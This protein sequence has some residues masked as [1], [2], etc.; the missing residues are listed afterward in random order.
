MKRLLKFVLLVLTCLATVVAVRTAGLTSKQIDAEPADLLAVDSTAVATKLS[1]AIQFPTVSYL[2][3]ERIDAAA[4]SAFDDW[5]REAFPRVHAGLERET[6]GSASLLFTWRGSEPT[7]PPSLLTAHFDVVPVEPGTENKWSHPPFS[8]AIAEG[9]VWGR[10]AMDDKMGVITALEAVESLLAQGFRPRRTVWLFFGADE[11]VSGHGGAA[12]FSQR[13]RET[14]TVPYFLLD[15]WMPILEG[16]IPGVDRPV[17]LVRIAEKAYLTVEVSAESEG[18]H[19]S[20]PPL[21]GAVGILARALTRIEDHPMPARIDGAVRQMFDVLAPEMPLGQRAVFANLWLFEPL[22]KRQLAGKPSTNAMIRTSAALT[23]LKGSPKDNVL[24]QRASAL[25]NFR[26]LPGDTVE[27]VLDHLRRTVRDPRVKLA[28]L[29]RPA[30]PPPPSATETPA[31]RAIE[32]AIR[33]VEP[34]ALVAP[35][36]LIG[37]SDARYY[38]PFC[39]QVFGFRAVRL[40]NE[41]L[42]RFH[43]TNERV[44][45][46]DLTRS[47]RFFAQVIR[48]ADGDRSTATTN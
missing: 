13:L 35:S 29:E 12:R 23:V 11:E 44:S 42:T 16:G 33:Q 36:L 40:R 43:G 31:Y 22:L 17:A 19:S 37:T 26:I 10:G 30:D 39:R 9:Y 25:V 48:N 21:E 41:D 20:S 2:E 24:P 5:L 45:L 34:S 46:D 7:L 15:E 27:E 3:A 14:G 6:I 8:G 4:F 32:K 18:G 28:P 1:R 47:V 38:E